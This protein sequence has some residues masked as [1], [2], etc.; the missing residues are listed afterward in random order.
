[1]TNVTPPNQ[2]VSDAVQIPVSFEI[3]VLGFAVMSV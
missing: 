1:M 2:I 3:S